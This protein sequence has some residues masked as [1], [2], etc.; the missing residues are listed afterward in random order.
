MPAESADTAR[1]EL[2][3]YRAHI[4]ALDE[5][6]GRLLDRLDEL[7]LAGDTLVVFTSDHGDMLHSQGRTRKQQPWE[8]SISVPLVFRG[9]GV[10]RGRVADGLIGVVDLLP[11]VL[12]LGGLAI[13][14]SVQGRDLSGLVRGQGPGRDA[15]VIMDICTGDE[16]F[17]QGVREWRGLRTARHTYARNIDRPWVLYDNEA[18]PFQLRNLAADPAHAELRE[19]LDRRL[20]AEL[21]G[22]GDAFRPWPELLRSLGLVGLWNQRE[23]HLHGEGGRFLADG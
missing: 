8:E 21:A 11:T 2:A 20:A 7:G 23:E 18:D 13:P 1:R 17:R 5:L 14:D 9:P 4:T 3:G 16:G 15:V 6:L 19:E 10:P 12:G 22:T